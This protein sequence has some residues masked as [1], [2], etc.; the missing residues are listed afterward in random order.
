MKSTAKVLVGTLPLRVFESNPERS[1][2]GIANMS[3]AAVIYV[4]SDSQLSVDSGFPI[5]PGTQMT[6]NEGNGDNTK[7][8]RWLISSQPATDV[9]IIEEYRGE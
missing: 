7:V 2:L 9:R 1:A 8:A 4:G 5:Y 6:F 3:G